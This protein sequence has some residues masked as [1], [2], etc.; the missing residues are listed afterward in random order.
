MDTNA[1]SLLIL[2]L[3]IGLTFAAHGAQR[4]FG[5]WGGPGLPGWEG[6]MEHMGFRPAKLFA[7]ASAGSERW[8][9]SHRW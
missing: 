7:L 2:Q 3:G 6:A 9:R 8:P 1:L 4:V 5:W